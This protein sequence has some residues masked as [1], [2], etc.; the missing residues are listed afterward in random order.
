MERL[1]S[2]ASQ[3]MLNLTIPAVCIDR[4]DYA[5]D[6]NTDR[7]IA[8]HVDIKEQH[9]RMEYSLLAISKW[10]AKWKKP[11]L[12]RFKGDAHTNEEWISFF[13]C[14]TINFQNVDDHCYDYLSQDLVDK[15]REYLEDPMTAT[16]FG[17]TD[18]S[19]GFSVITAEV[20][21]WQMIQNGIPMEWEKRNFN[22]LVTLIRVCAAKS[23]P[24]KMSRRQIMEQHRALHEARRK[25]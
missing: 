9:L 10:E 5:Y 16:T 2:L 4:D 20:I 15:I 11:F 3:R 17:M 21:Y 6:E 1:I 8:L 13:K 7:F 25:H 14:M 22:Q 12:P 24:K 19:S 18:E 23:N